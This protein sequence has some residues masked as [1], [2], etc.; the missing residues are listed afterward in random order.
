MD[1]TYLKSL[2]D[3]DKNTGLFQW[4]VRRSNCTKKGWFFGTA[5]PDGYYQ[6]SI[7]KKTYLCHKLTWLWSMGDLPEV[8]DHI[9]E[10]KQDN[11][12]CNLRKS[13]HSLN[14]LNQAR[15]HQ[16]SLSPYRGVSKT[17]S[18]KWMAKYCFNNKQIYLGSFD[19]PED[20]YKIYT[21]TKERLLNVSM[22]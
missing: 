7:D 20:A 9:N 12:L 15:R 17:A 10:N 18:G 1:Q 4:R 21:E 13:N 14:G 2:L 6:L 19:Y 22:D 5:R 11:R 8:L 3:Y 16:D